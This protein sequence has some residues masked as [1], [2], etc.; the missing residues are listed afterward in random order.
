M[1]KS[2]SS[3]LGTPSLS[4]VAEHAGV[5]PITVSR[6]LRTP[7]KVSRHLRERI[8]AAVAKLGYVPNPA[9]S[10]LASTVSTTI[11]LILPS[12]TN[13]V[14]DD[15]LHGLYDGLGDAPYFLQIGNSH[16][17]AL[18]EEAL[19]RQFIR[20]KPAAFIV[21]GFGQT[22]QSNR[23]LK[24][25]RCPVVQIMDTGHETID[26]SVGFDHVAAGAAAARHFLDCNYRKLGYMGA[27][28]DAR[29]QQ[30]MK[31]F[32]EAA[33]GI[34]PVEDRRIATSP[35]ESSVGLGRQL[36]EQLLYRAPDTDAV[37]CNNDDLAVGALVEARRRRFDVPKA[38]GICS[39]HDNEFARHMIPPITAIATP[40]MEIGK[41]AIEMVLKEIG[42][43]NSVRDRH[44]DL[45][46]EL[47]HRETTRPV[48][49]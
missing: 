35:G 21:T 28:L 17:S 45:G 11:A 49:G 24:N 33:A 29:S 42:E 34:A 12:L 40:R 8:E 3:S 14:F 23:M 22:E 20:Q 19:I 26:M 48:A 25:A 32:I 27:R 39:F 7:E 36:L 18:K 6:A 38:L 16:Y 47:V 46:F 4:D 13:T 15:V 37:F 1:T 10:A 41:R 43:P 44:C 2:R 5:S 30:R 9:A 31:G